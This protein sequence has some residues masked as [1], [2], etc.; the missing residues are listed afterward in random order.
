VLYRYRPFAAGVA[1]SLCSIKPHLLLPFGAVL[2]LWVIQRKQ[3][4]LL[5]GLASGLLALAACATLLRPSIWGDYLRLMGSAETSNMVVPSAS[6]LLRFFSPSSAWLAYI[7][8]AFGCGWAVWYFLRQS[9][10]EW[11]S[12]AAYMLLLV[13]LWVAPYAFMLDEVLALPALLWVFYNCRNRVVLGV[14]SVMVLVASAELLHSVPVTSWGYV[15]T[16]TAWVACYVL[17]HVSERSARS[18]LY[19]NRDAEGLRDR[20]TVGVRC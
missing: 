14:L 3:W 12:Q 17:A 10:W 6:S 13:S 16:N 20:A 8:I 18:D 5:L 15:W 7:P 1:L 11:D 4:R 2:L 9:E 19:T